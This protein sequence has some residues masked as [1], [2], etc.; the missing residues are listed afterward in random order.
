MTLENSMTQ[1]GAHHCKPKRGTAINK[2]TILAMCFV[3]QILEPIYKSTYLV[4]KQFQNINKK[5]ELLSYD[6]LK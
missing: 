1:T 3:L 2:K 4:N 5:C 6:F